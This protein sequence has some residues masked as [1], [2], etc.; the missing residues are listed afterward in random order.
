MAILSE[1]EEPDAAPGLASACNGAWRGFVASEC[2][3]VVKD[4]VDTSTDSSEV[5]EKWCCG[6]A[7]V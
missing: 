7:S 2:D 4:D 6:L 3:F 5:A 1:C